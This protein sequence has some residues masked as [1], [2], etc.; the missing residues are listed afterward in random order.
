MLIIGVVIGAFIGVGVMS[1]LQI[2]KEK[3]EA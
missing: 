3:K 2:N 1:L